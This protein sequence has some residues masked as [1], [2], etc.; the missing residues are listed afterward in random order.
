[1]LERLDD[2]K[3]RIAKWILLSIAFA[4]IYFLTERYFKYT[5]NADFT[6]SPLM[7]RQIKDTTQSHSMLTWT[8]TPDSWYFSV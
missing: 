5:V 6:N 4:C 7:W 2:D 8:P 3:W 1:M